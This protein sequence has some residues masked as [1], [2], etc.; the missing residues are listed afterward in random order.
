[1]STRSYESPAH[2]DGET[3]EEWCARYAASI[4]PGALLA[5]IVV[6]MH[7]RREEH[8]PAWAQLRDLCGHGSG[9]SSAIV[10]SYFPEPVPED[11]IR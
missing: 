1:M 10:K 3:N 8:G 2:H 7:E 5:E 9:V 11:A 6:R 4:P